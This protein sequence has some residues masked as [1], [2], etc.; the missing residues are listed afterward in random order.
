MSKIKSVYEKTLNLEG[1]KTVTLTA[2]ERLIICNAMTILSP[3]EVDILPMIMIMD[4][5]TRA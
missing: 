3:K 2:E 4:K 1:D 5:L